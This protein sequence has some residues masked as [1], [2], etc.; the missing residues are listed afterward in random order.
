MQVKPGL[1]LTILL[2]MITSP[3]FGRDVT[4]SF[5]QEK[6]PY[7][8]TEDGK[9]LGIERD[10]LAAALQAVGHQLVATQ[11]P[12]QRLIATYAKDQFDFA[13]GLQEGDVADAFYSDEYMFFEN[14]AIS[15]KSKNITVKRVED[16]FQHHVAIWQHGYV[17]LGF[18]QIQP[19][20]ASGGIPDNFHEFPLMTA[21]A[22]FFWTDRADIMVVDRHIFFYFAKLLRDMVDTSEPVTLHA[23]FPSRRGVR[24]AFHDRALRDD[25]NRGLAMI[26]SDGRYDEILS[27]YM[28]AE[29]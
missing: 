19:L 1:I 24:C 20:S 12:N 22:K 2:L 14:Y 23:I 10:I 25:F 7:L 17:D 6:P 28:S 3:L 29:G 16:L 9:V 18:D 21:Q 11:M 27:R 8:W 5:G 15:K 26:K 13:A 4:G